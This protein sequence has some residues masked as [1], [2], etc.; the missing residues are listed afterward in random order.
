MYIYIYKTAAFAGALL[1]MLPENQ[2]GG[3]WYTQKSLGGATNS[4]TNL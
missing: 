1:K 2:D 4:I 3:C